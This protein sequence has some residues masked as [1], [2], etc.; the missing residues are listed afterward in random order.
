MKISFAAV[1]PVSSPSQTPV[2]YQS[3]ENVKATAG[4]GKNNAY[5]AINAAFRKLDGM[6]RRNY[7]SCVKLH[8]AVE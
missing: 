3:L 7:D 4:S 1:L 5:I 2:N 6:A 8:M